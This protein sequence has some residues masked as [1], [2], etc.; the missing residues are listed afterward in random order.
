MSKRIIVVTSAVLIAASTAAYAMFNQAMVLSVKRADPINGACGSA[1]GVAT[2][3]APTSNLCSIGAA[4]AV[5]GTGPW[6]W[7]CGGSSGGTNASC[8]APLTG[9]GGVPGPAQSAG[10]TTLVTSADFTDPFYATQSN[11]LNCHNQ[12]GSD[13]VPGGSAGDG[14][15]TLY[16]AWEGFGNNFTPPCSAQSQ[17]TDPID[18]T[19]SMQLNYRDEYWDTING[20]VHYADLST[21]NNSGTVNRIPPNAYYEVVGRYDVPRDWTTMDFWS[22]WSSAWEFD[23]VEAWFPP[24]YGGDASSV[25]QDLGSGLWFGAWTGN[26]P[27][28]GSGFD[29]AAYHKY[30]WRITSSGPSGS[31]AQSWYCSYI[32]DQQQGNCQRWDN[33]NFT[34][35]NGE[36]QSLMLQ[37][38][39]YCRGSNQCNPGG[40]V[41]NVWVRSFRV[42]SCD[43]MNSSSKCFTS[44]PN[45]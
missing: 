34:N 40:N 27:C 5:T 11:W 13:G 45:P 21:T 33:G 22:H 2:S 20:N 9:G 23:G 35:L 1:S 30:S 25:V 39:G 10:F 12:N 14:P 7:T 18:N 19:K 15:R 28:C 26:P 17:Q 36:T 41:T 6:S 37:G 29:W 24:N 44:N 4:S 16:R 32:D 38:G 42:F 31:P 3:S 8:S 43:V